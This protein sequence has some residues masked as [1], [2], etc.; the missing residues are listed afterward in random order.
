VQL[1]KVIDAAVIARNDDLRLGSVD[2]MF[3]RFKG[4]ETAVGEHMLHDTGGKQGMPFGRADRRN[5]ATR[6]GEIDGNAGGSGPSGGVGEENPG[7]CGARA[8]RNDIALLH[9]WLLSNFRS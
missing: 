2:G 3:Q 5:G 8:V 7:N 4:S 6:F 9:A 1:V